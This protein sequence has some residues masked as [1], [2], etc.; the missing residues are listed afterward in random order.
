MLFF[1]LFLGVGYGFKRVISLGDDMSDTGNFYRLSHYTVPSSNYYPGRFSNGPVWMEHIAQNFSARLQ[2]YAYYGATSD[3]DMY[4]V[5]PGYYIPGCIQQLAQLNNSL[6]R[7]SDILLHMGFFGHDFTSTTSISS[8]LGNLERCLSGLLDMTKATHVVLPVSN[9][10]DLT[11]LV[12]SYNFIYRFFARRIAAA[13][14]EES[15]KGLARISKQYPGVRIYGYDHAAFMRAAANGTLEYLNNRTLISD[16][17]CLQ[18]MP[19]KTES[20]CHNPQDYLFW[21][22]SHPTHVVHKAMADVITDLIRTGSSRF[23]RVFYTP[24]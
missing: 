4:Q 22:L 20:V 17:C 2:S 19:D 1:L 12:Q 9:D 8:S 6:P 21:D 3:G 13:I 16:K 15:E 11:P 5:V 18:V 10:P 14:P 23:G 7:T 24:T